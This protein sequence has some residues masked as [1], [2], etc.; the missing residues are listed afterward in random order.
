MA[1]SVSWLTTGDELRLV[2]ET[3][4]EDD[5]P[6]TLERAARGLRRDLIEFDSVSTEQVG[7]PD[8]PGAKGDI[9]LLG[10]IAVSTATRSLCVGAR[11]SLRLPYFSSRSTLSAA[12]KASCGTS[13][14]PTIFIR[15][16]PSFCRSRSFFLRLMSPP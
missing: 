12:T 6:E 14:E 11:E 3:F 15:F 8:Q 2:F 7:G 16:F 13:T 9:G 4:E 5:E 1:G 10:T